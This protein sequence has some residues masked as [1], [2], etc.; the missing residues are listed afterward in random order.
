MEWKKQRNVALQIM[1]SL[2]YGKHA[3]EKKI[4]EEALALRAVLEKTVGEK[5]DPEHL[6]NISIA[7]VICSI[8][9]GQRY[10]YDDAEFEHVVKVCPTWRSLHHINVYCVLIAYHQY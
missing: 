1:R 6:L 10:E 8:L 9:F 2:G 5:T 7:N 4:S 3:L